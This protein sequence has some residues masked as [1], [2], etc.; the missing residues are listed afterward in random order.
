MIAFGLG[1]ALRSLH[2]FLIKGS[3]PSLCQ[4]C[5]LG[6]RALAMGKLPWAWVAGQ[7]WGWWTLTP[8]GCA[9]VFIRSGCVFT[10][11]AR[12]HIIQESNVSCHRGGKSEI[13][14]K[15]EYRLSPRVRMNHEQELETRPGLAGQTGSGCRSWAKGMLGSAGL[16][17]CGWAWP[18][19]KE[20]KVQSAQDLHEKNEIQGARVTFLRSQGFSRS[21]AGLPPVM[22]GYSMCIS[23]YPENLMF[24][25]SGAAL[26]CRNA[27]WATDVT[28]EFLVATVE[29]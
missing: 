8:R 3:A 14:M 13:W 24:S 16:I 2:S 26:S 21:R 27:L 4:A 7:K 20:W 28:L 29:T 9:G 10:G 17:P 25:R 19:Y 15:K 12:N 11:M 1:W 6:L 5:W 18:V 22:H 23:N